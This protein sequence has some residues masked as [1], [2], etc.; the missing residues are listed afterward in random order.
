MEIKESVWLSLSVLSCSDLR[1]VCGIDISVFIPA[2]YEIRT[3]QL[4][5]YTILQ[6]IL[7]KASTCNIVCIAVIKSAIP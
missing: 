2:L 1:F 3:V 5:D 7:D 4:E 6:F